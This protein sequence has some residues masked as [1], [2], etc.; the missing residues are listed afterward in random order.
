MT[1][2]FIEL[3]G[4]K[5]DIEDLKSGLKS[6]K[7]K[8]TNEGT[9]YYLSSEIIDELTD[10]REIISKA[11]EFL[12]TIN[13]AANILYSNHQRVQTG[14]LK[15]MG[16][17]G[18]NYVIVIETAYFKL[19]S[20]VRGVISTKADKSHSQTTIETWLDKSEKNKSVRD[21]LH[22]F[23]EITWWNLYKIYEIINDDVKGQKGL[24]KLIDKTE[25]SVFTQAAQSREFL[26]DK[27]RH[28][29]RKYT[30]PKKNITIDQACDL[31]IKLFDK[32]VSTK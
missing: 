18:A 10:N 13:G 9:K 12:N 31:I 26:G 22:F 21:V 27:A 7:W 29:S 24:H 2:V 3:S 5:L 16:P 20:R 19:N 17:N 6:F 32:W 15:I 11:N 25:L 28:A 4:D 23:N 30:P 1:R 14:S 8:I